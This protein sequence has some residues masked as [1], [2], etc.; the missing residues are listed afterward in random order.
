MPLSNSF[1]SLTRRFSIGGWLLL[2]WFCF[3]VAPELDAQ[4]S[5]AT[6]R[7]TGR[8]LDDA[9]GPVRN[10]SV[11][12]HAAGLAT[13]IQLI[14]APNGGIDASA[15]A[16][17]TYRVCA[18]G[19]QGS[20]TLD[21]C[22]W[23]E[24]APEVIV[25]AGQTTIMPNVV[26][27]SGTVLQVRIVDTAKQLSGRS[28]PGMPLAGIWTEKL[29]FFPL[30]AEIAPDGSTTYKM[31][32]PYERNLTFTAGGGAVAYQ[33]AGRTAASPQGVKERIRLARPAGPN[34]TVTLTVVG[35]AVP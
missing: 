10:A 33:A 35:A 7:L 8:I 15:I 17:G 14:A 22:I 26:L 23:A 11:T 2:A 18:R 3:M 29:L 24:R 27:E 12:L 28:V 25:R 1:N 32:V 13:P 6:G 21:P 16:P 5:G 30:P 31:L 19:P 4:V 20:L 9:G 34:Q